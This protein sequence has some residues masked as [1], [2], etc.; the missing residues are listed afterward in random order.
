M[1]EVARASYCGADTNLAE[2]TCEACKHDTPAFNIVPN[3]IRFISLSDLG[4][5]YAIFIFVAKAEVIEDVLETTP[6]PSTTVEMNISST[7]NATDVHVDCVISF[8]GTHSF[9]NLVRDLQVHM[10]P[11]DDG[12]TG[13]CPGCKVETGDYEVWKAAKEPIVRTLQELGCEPGGATQDLYVTGHSLGA[14]VG[15]I[16]MFA[17][18]DLGFDVKRSFLFAS[19]MPGNAAF[20]NAFES[21]FDRKTAAWRVT[22]AKDPVVHL[23]PWWFGFSTLATEVYY[24]PGADADGYKVCH[25]RWDKSCSY[26][27]DLATTLQHIG[28]HCFTPLLDNGN[29]CTPP[30]R[31]CVK[32][33]VSTV[34]NE[35]VNLSFRLLQAF[36]EGLKQ[37]EA[38]DLL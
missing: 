10:T 1:A 6:G 15:F 3:S 29:F 26:Q 36:A 38:G 27:W 25:G 37:P 35:I 2:W 5:D 34:P 19:P 7:E 30:P 14:A 33:G 11:F 8:R 31:V 12:G 9:K 17:L 13:S 24:P 20:A 4:S 21:R 32:T 16:G 23:P 22:H 18:Q 28:D